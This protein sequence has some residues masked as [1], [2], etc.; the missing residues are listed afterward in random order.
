[1]LWVSSELPRDVPNPLDTCE[2]YIQ[3]RLLSTNV[4]KDTQGPGTFRSENRRARQRSDDKHT[5]VDTTG[6][7][8]ANA[9]KVYTEVRG[10]ESNEKYQARVRG[11]KQAKVETKGRFRISTLQCI[12]RGAATNV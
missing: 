7:C 1:M 5:K 4:V 3:K 6:R 8:K 9:R 10:S 2:I 11:K 12:Q